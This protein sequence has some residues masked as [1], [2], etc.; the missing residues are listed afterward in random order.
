MNLNQSERNLVALSLALID[1]NSRLSRAEA[2]M[3]GRV[4]KGTI[5]REVLRRTVSEICRGMDPLGE[6][7]RPTR[8]GAGDK[9]PHD[10]VDVMQWWISG[11]PNPARFTVLNAG[12]GQLLRPLS[13]AFPQSSFVAIENDPLAAI[14]LRANLVILK[15][16]L[17]TRIVCGREEMARLPCSI[18]PVAYLGY[19]DN[20]PEGDESLVRMLDATTALAQPGDMAT[21]LVP[22]DA[23]EG[24]R[25]ADMW[26]RRLETV[27][28]THVIFL[29]P[30]DPH[31]TRMAL[32]CACSGNQSEAIRIAYSRFPMGTSKPGANAWLNVPR[33]WLQD[34]SCWVNFW[35]AS[36]PKIKTQSHAV[37]LS[38]SLPD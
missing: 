22:S 25:G 27:G 9:M 1:G 10:V 36:Q 16:H 7:L 33:K 37:S 19:G 12:T 18:G 8:Y 21:F 38:V 11:Q 20:R 28:V 26:R 13:Q 14:A 30:R 3:G 31:K 5:S 32:V 4:D 15:L 2:E 17:R 6:Y 29:E 24:K 23:L 35:N 34:A